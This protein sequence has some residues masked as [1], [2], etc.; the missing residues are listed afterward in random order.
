MDK[1]RALIATF[2]FQLNMKELERLD[3]TGNV[4]SIEH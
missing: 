3:C 4:L 2:K 1:A